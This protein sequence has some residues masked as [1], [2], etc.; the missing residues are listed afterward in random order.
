MTICLEV[1]EVK[2]AS[3]RYQFI[4][5][6]TFQTWIYRIFKIAAMDKD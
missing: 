1:I 4:K 3:M 6:I 5:R 2:N